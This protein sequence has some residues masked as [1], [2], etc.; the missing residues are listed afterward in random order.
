MMKAVLVVIALTWTCTHAFFWTFAYEYCNDDV[1]SLCLPSIAIISMEARLTT[2]MMHCSSLSLTPNVAHY[3]SI[4][5]QG[6]RAM[7]Y[8][9]PIMIGRVKAFSD[10]R[11]LKAWGCS[12]KSTARAVQGP[13][14]LYRMY[15]PLYNACI[16][17][18]TTPIRLWLYICSIRQMLLEIYNTL[19]KSVM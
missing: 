19:Y 17:I 18:Y 3:S 5:A 8:F 10:F 13:E 16:V 6:D 4:P 12:I 7:R 11:D 2:P 1:C 9:I 15:R 14:C